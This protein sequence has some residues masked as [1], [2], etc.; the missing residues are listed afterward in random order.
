MPKQE[1]D[2]P[3]VLHPMTF[4]DALKRMVSTPP[5]NPA[6]RKTKKRKRKAGPRRSS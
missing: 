2:K 3:V 1:D 4:E 6:K 5:V